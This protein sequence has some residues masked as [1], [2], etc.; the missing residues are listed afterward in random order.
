M[1]K[2][3]DDFI[4]RTVKYWNPGKTLEW[5]RPASTSSSTG[6]RATTSTT[7]IGRRLI[8]VHLNGGTYQLGHRNPEVIAAVRAGMDHFDIGNHHFPAL[9]RTRLAEM[10]AEAF[11][12]RPA[13]Y[14][15]WL[16]RRRGDRHRAEERT[17][18]HQA[19]AHHL[20]RALLSRPYRSCGASRRRPVLEAFPSEASPRSHQGPFQRSRRHGARDHAR[21]TPPA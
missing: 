18:R 19:A 17:A 2:A 16:G 6:A 10:L 14:D 8:D 1:S 11:A 20:S 5:Q 13:L 12:G 15:V 9:M 7:W 4:A 21:A 3:K